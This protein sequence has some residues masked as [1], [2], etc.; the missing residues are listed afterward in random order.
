LKQPCW[1]AAHTVIEARQ[2]ILLTD[3]VA[4]IAAIRRDWAAD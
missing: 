2:D 1:E 3:Q 4:T